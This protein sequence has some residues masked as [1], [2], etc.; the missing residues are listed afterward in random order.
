MDMKIHQSIGL[1][2]LNFLTKNL[3]YLW[4]DKG[5]RSKTLT[6]DAAQCYFSINNCKKIDGKRK[7]C[8][9]TT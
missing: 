5:I 2:E 4:L 8:E 9:S 7:I 3:Q 1:H 6:A